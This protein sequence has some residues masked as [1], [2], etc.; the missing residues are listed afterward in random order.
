MKAAARATTVPLWAWMLIAAPLGACTD[1]G[2]YSRDAPPIEA[3][4]VALTGRACSD[5]PETARFPARVVLVVDQAAGPLFADFDPGGTR[6]DVLGRF[7][8]SALTRPEYAF[9]IVGYA[10]RAA[11]L[12]PLV[13]DPVR[14]GAF[15]RNPG[16]LLNALTRLSLPGACLGADTCRDY[17]DGLRAARAVIEDDLAAR[18]RGLTATTQY[19][20]VLVNAGPN[21]PQANLSACC[22]PGDD[23]C[24]EGND[25]PSVPCQ[26]QLDVARVEALRDTVVGAGAAGFQL[27]AMH[28]AASGDATADDQ[29]AENHRQLAFAGGGRYVRFG[30]A[31]AVDVAPLRLFDRQNALRVKRLVIANRSALPTADGLRPDSD[32]DGLADADEAEFGA[33]PDLA[34]TDGD[35][36]G[37]LVEVLVGQS[38]SMMDEP[39]AC[40]ALTP[41]ADLDLDG[42]TDCDEAL[43]GT[44]RSLV[45]TDGDGLP[46]LLE[47]A[48][49][50]DYLAPDQVA[51]AD[52]DGIS[53][54]DEVRDHTDPRSADLPARLGEAYRYTIDDLGIVREPLV[55]ALR[56]LPGVEIIE[57]SG[58]STPGQARVRWAPG[59]GLAW[60]DAGDEAPGPFVP[61]SEA[62]E[63]TVELGSSSFAPIQ[64][65]DGRRVRVRV[66]PR[67]LPPTESG[68]AVRVAFRERHCVAYTVRNIRLLTLRPGADG[69]RGAVNNLYLYLAQAPAGD[70]TSPGP[71]RLAHVPIRYAA[72]D[73]REPWGAVLEVLDDEL[74][75]PRLDL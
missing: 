55:P 49:G 22:A 30:A 67:E 3:D 38:P 41:G 44:D 43:L 58:G 19:V 1:A 53:N 62:D 9:A 64:G 26:R 59:R 29:V 72:P 45:D 6:I 69:G 66:R 4:R 51:D 50:T 2:L 71:F 13:E 47:V 60:Q 23:R 34:D 7:V 40:A 32:G 73:F 8:Q 35:G 39:F 48:Y 57:V 20:V 28:L 11:R 75:R 14:P 24:P 27:H 18:P 70:P 25:G 17:A 52:G 10:G 16:E 63:Q 74:V 56:S 33:D 46:D 54:G 5:D 61:L 42:L 37:D 65:D 15:T 36:A 21:V 12:A 31:G 68:E